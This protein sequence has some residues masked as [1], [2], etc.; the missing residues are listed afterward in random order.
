MRQP[1]AYPA[2]TGTYDR[3]DEIRAYL[4]TIPN[5]FCI[6]A[7]LGALRQLRL[8]ED[9]YR[10]RGIEIKKKILTPATEV[11]SAAV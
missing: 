5:L 9:I 11:A 8:R 7:T 10:G 1:K 2:Y 4:D 3:F 6:K